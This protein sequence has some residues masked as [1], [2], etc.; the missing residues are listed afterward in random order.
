MSAAGYALYESGCL[1]VQ[2]NNLQLLQPVSFSDEKIKARSRR[3]FRVLLQDANLLSTWLLTFDVRDHCLDSDA[4]VGLQQPGFGSPDIFL[5]PIT[6]LEDR[7][8]PRKWL[9]PPQYVAPLVKTNKNDRNDAEAIVETPSGQAMQFAAVKIVTELA[10]LLNALATILDRPSAGVAA[11]QHGADHTEP[12]HFSMQGGYLRVSTA[13]GIIAPDYPNYWVST[14][15]FPA[16]VLLV[17]ETLEGTSIT[18]DPLHS[19][20]ILASP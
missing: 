14:P 16:A 17:K 20:S 4:H 7:F 6:T 9:L 10:D 8:S 1:L 5:L 19:E 18:I 12:V 2:D 11:Q 15:D 13:R 3:H